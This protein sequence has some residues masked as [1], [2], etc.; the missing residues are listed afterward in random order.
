M[1][2]NTPTIPMPARPTVQIKQLQAASRRLMVMP[3]DPERGRYLVASEGDPSR[4][5][6]V[7]LQRG[8]LAGH[9]TCLWAQ[10]GGINCKH[11]LAALRAHYAPA[12]RLS[13][14]PSRDAAERQHRRILPGERLYATLRPRGQRRREYEN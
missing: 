11:V 8:E 13:F 10:Y 4:A 7:S 14:W 5:Y 2:T 6:E 12:G 3:R 1:T 9:C